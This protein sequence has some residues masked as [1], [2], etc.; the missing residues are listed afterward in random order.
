MSS[1]RLDSDAIAMSGPVI[2]LDNS[3]VSLELLSAEEDE[4]FSPG[5]GRQRS[6]SNAGVQLTALGNGA[7][8]A[9]AE[10]DT[11][12]LLRSSAESSASDTN[13]APSSADSAAG[14]AAAT[15]SC[16]PTEAASFVGSWNQISTDN[17]DA[18]LKEVVGLTYV[19][20]R[21][22]LRI[23]PAPTWWLD[24][25]GAVLWCKV[26]C[27]GA[28]P[29]EESYR[30][31]EEHSEV[32]DANVPGVVWKVRQWWESG[33]VLCSEKASASQNGGRPITCRRQTSQGGM[34]LVVTQEWA[35]GK[36]F[37]QT[38]QRIESGGTVK[39]QKSEGM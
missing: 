37:T 11:N 23:K 3:N 38:L 19:T 31:F 14:R 27:F 36:V 6:G 35:P 28:K 9:V 29:I 13:G 33:G 24:E 4:I 26:E 1:I 8:T 16:L 10:S 18:F 7:D 22:A 39:Y 5:R 2:Q 32:I 34:R 12:G 17:Y 21:I 20:R 25:R 15:S 30:A